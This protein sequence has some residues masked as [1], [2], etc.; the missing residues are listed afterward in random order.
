MMIA[1]RNILARRLIRPNTRKAES[2]MIDG[3]NGTGGVWVRSSRCSP[4]NNCVELR[5]DPES[6]RVR[7]S[8][9]GDGPQLAFDQSSWRT[10]LTVAVR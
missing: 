3:A 5:L 10:F 6:V 8:K 1:A 4:N 7:D 9:A 2:T